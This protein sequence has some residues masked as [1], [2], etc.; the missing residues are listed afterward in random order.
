M[1]KSR[2]C[3]WLGLAVCLC[4]NSG[5]EAKAVKS[6]QNPRVEVVTNMGRFEL[7]L[8]PKKAP[9]TVKNFLK[10]V[11]DGFYDNTIFHRV[12]NGFMIQGGGFEEGLKKK[13][14]RKPIM[15]E[16]HNKLSNVLGT[17]A[18]ART[19]D[20]H[21]ATAQFYINVANNTFLNYASAEQPGYCVFGTVYKGLDVIQDIKQVD[22]ETNGMYQNVPKIPV[23]IK[24]VRVI[25]KKGPQKDEM[26]VPKE[27][28]LPVS[29]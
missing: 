16:S 15:N 2:L 1:K 23:I 7:E 19:N 26:H 4:L 22:V 21:S 11:N 20:P 24:R 29:S 25:S 28:D 27:K 9:A 13:P 5:V 3:L 18:M 12:I 10:Y 14:T 8:Y 17:I 6:K